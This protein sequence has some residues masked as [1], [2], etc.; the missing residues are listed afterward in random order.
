MAKIK[1]FGKSA[2]L[3]NEDYAKIR[4][5]LI[6]D[7]HKLILDIARYTG[8]R[9]GAILKLQVE[10]VWDSSG[11]VRDS[12][13]F[14]AHTRKAS[15]DGKRET[16]E[17]PTH[18]LLKEALSR[19]PK[20]NSGYLFPGMGGKSLCFQAASACFCRATVKAG[21]DAKGFS[22]HSTRRTFITN[23][24]RSGVDIATIKAITGHRDLKSLGGYIEMDS[25][26]IK[27]AIALL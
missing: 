13:T 26:R 5:S 14:K 9:W 10:D 19:Y 16:R 4:K 24:H 3:T 27:T 11:R 18:P 25:D 20:P 1:G 21:L 2:I 6:S 22:T 15:P 23:L 7:H 12:I 17:V 8:E